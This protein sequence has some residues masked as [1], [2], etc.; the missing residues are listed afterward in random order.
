M[1][2]LDNFVKQF[3]AESHENLDKLDRTLVELEKYPRSASR[4]ASIFRTIHSIKGTSSFFGFSKE[5]LIK[6]PIIRAGIYKECW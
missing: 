6:L 2:E 4:L 3:L 1:S 5:T